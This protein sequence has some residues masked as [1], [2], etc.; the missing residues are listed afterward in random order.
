MERMT[1]AELISHIKELEKAREAR[2]KQ[3]DIDLS[4]GET[5]KEKSEHQKAQEEKDR[6]LRG[7]NWRFTSDHS[8]KVAT[9]EIYR[10]QFLKEAE[11]RRQK[12]LERIKNG[13]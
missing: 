10:A 7:S 8:R 2:Q 9:D 11:A 3:V 1:K 6:A 4:F 13:K 5:P 12:T